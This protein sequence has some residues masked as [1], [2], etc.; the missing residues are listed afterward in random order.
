[1][2][3]KQNRLSSNYEDGCVIAK[4]YD[5]TNLPSDELLYADI[6]NIIE[7][8]QQ[9]IYDSIDSSVNEN[10]ESIISEFPSFEAETD[11]RKMRQHLR[12]ERDDRKLIQEV[13][14]RKGYICECCKIDF[15]K[16]YGPIGKGYIEAH[17]KQPIHQ[18]KGK[19]IKLDAEKD[20]IVLCSNCHKMIH[21]LD[22][23]SDLDA[24]IKLYKRV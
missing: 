8:Y 12:I 7:T 17:H 22:D 24:F 20:F 14:K 9:I 10:S 21:K 2:N 23:P 1:M 3:A 11:L 6:D 15:E 18:L 16:T 19:V 4:Y 5:S 13:K